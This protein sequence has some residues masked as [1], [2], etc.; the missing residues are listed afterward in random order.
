MIEFLTSDVFSTLL[1]AI[2]P[3]LG[4]AALVLARRHLRWRRGVEMLQRLGDL[5]AR[6][7]VAVHA[8]YSTAII[9]GRADGRLD[10]DERAEAKR[11][12]LGKLREYAGWD[13][14]MYVVGTAPRADVALNDAI[15][16]SLEAAKVA[17]VV[18]RQK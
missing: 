6:A 10:D 5:A 17:S 11:R 2:I 14:I 7:V 3:L 8:E 12:A 18:P 13:D 1:A 4:G 9:Q 16:A 15:E